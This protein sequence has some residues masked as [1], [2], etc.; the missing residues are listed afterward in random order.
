[1][2]RLGKGHKGEM[3][4]PGHTGGNGCLPPEFSGQGALLQ[5]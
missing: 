3:V 2:D 5:G 4:V 1:M